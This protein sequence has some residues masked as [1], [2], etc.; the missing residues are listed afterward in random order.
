MEVQ[1]SFLSYALRTLLISIQ[2]YLIRTAQ[3]YDLFQY[4]RFNSSVEGARWDEEQKKWETS[5]RIDGGK[6][7][8][9]GEHYTLTSDFLVSAVG[10]LNLPHY[11]EISGLDEF[12][13]K[14]M[15]S[16]RWDWDYHFDGKR[17]G[18]IGNGKWFL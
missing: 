1:G 15:H 11:P 16:A 6:D 18:I 9:F 12:Q 3:K 8:E 2:K 14:M 5:V 10:Q 17:I 13:G 7:A 4:I